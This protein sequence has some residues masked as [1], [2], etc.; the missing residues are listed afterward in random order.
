MENKEIYMLPFIGEDTEKLADEIMKLA[1]EARSQDKNTNLIVK[2]ENA[3]TYKRIF[4][5]P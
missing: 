2:K 5:H 4:L 3:G 1:I